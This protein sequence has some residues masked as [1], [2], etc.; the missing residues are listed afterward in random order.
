MKTSIRNHLISLSVL[1][2]LSYTACTLKAVEIL[3]P[4]QSLNADQKITSPGGIFELGFFTPGNSQHYYIGIWYKNLPQQTVVWVANR[5]QPII[6]PTSSSLVLLENGNLTLNSPS[7]VA[8]WSANSTPQATN[9]TIAMLLDNGNFVIRDASSVLWQSFDHPTDT[10]LPGARLGFNKLTKKIQSVT[11]WRNPQYPAPGPFSFELEQSRLR[12][13]WNSS[14]TYWTSGDWTG[15]TFSHIQNIEEKYVPSIFSFVVNE[16]GSYL[17]YAVRASAYPDTF[18]H[19]FIRYMIETTGQIKFFVL[20]KGTLQ[21]NL[22]WMQPTKQCDVYA[23]CGAFSICNPLNLPR[24]GCLKGFRPK[25]PKDWELEDHSNGCGRKTSFHCSDEG[26][27]AF[28]VMKNVTYPKSPDSLAVDNI[29]KCRLA[30]LRN[31]SCTAFA[32]DSQCLIWGGDLFNVTQL[33]SEGMIGKVWYLR[34]AASEKRMTTWIVVGVLAGIFTLFSIALVV[35][36][37]RKSTGALE[38]FEQSLVLFNYRDLRKATENFSEKIGE[39]AFGSVFKGILRDSTPI[40]VKQLKSLWHVEKQF[41]AEVRTLGTIQHIN[42][43]RLRGF[44]A[45]YTRRLLVYDYVANG[46]L[47]SVLFQKHPLILDW[48]ARY[49]IAIGIARG[50]AYLHE[51]C[52]DCII[53]CDIKPENILLD[54]EYSPKVADFGLAKLIGRHHSRVLTT[55][56][57]TVGYLA[58]EWFTGEA[59]TPKADVFSYGKLL[60]EVISGRRNTEGLDDGLENYIPNRIANVVTRGQDVLTLVD[61]RLEGNA[62]KDELIRACKVACWCIQDEEKDRPTMRRVVQILEGALDVGIPPIPQFLQFLPG[63]SMEAINC[64]QPTSSSEIIFL[65]SSADEWL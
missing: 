56:R 25:F 58:P 4:G 12:L 37:R 30:C 51:D 43:L 47:Q 15:K 11:P 49:H 38:S 16:T 6:D 29:G 41:Q 45:E 53:H 27:S 17:T 18:E 62:D 10:W 7:T 44:C 14:E 39:G 23:S 28:L 3:L 24:C 60:F 9:S 1:L 59:I 50:L 40:A 32:Y 42:L 35:V 21:W 36:R 54:E 22:L 26:N 64:Q 57:G 20:E 46:S 33:S 61:Y 55:V 8:I 2:L 19:T 48:K 65:S 13:L 31:C 5:H 63:S 52:R 34:V